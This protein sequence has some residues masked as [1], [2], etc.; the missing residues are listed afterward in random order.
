MTDKPTSSPRAAQR[1]RR[2]DRR[3]AIKRAAIDVFAELGYHS[4]K[5]SQI[6]ERVGVAQGTF[7][8]YYSSKQQLFGELLDD[9]LRLVVETIASW[10]P[11]A[12]S[13][14]EDLQR[15]LTR[16][17][18]MLTSVL[19]EHSGL[20]AIF[21]K[22]AL[23]VS[24]EFDAVVHEFYETLTAMLSTFNSILCDRGLI[25]KMNF[26]LLA[27]M[28]IG[29]V[30]RIIMEYIV[31]KRLEGVPLNELVDHLVAHFMTGT[32]EPVPTLS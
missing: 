3:E 5:V 11:A 18:R 27:L 21:F 23:T 7:Y 13:T 6:V 17:G 2:E 12:V 20:A 4:A 8:L 19:Y 30:E 15:E 28:T 31:Y 14:R 9:F 16:V 25:K 1:R 22:E 24:S 26:H 29:Q 10:E 32:L